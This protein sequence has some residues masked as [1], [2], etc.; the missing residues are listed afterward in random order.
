MCPVAGSSE[1]RTDTTSDFLALQ[2]AA[3]I[4]NLFHGVRRLLAAE[5][6]LSHDLGLAIP[7]F[8][9]SRD[10]PSEFFR[11]ST[12]PSTTQLLVLGERLSPL[13][14]R[15]SAR[16]EMLYRASDLLAAGSES[17]KAGL[18]SEAIASFSE[19]ARLVPNSTVIAAALARAEEALQTGFAFPAAP[20]PADSDDERDRRA[21]EGLAHARALAEAGSLETAIRLLRDLA[22]ELPAR[23]DLTDELG[24]LRASVHEVRGESSSG[25]GPTV[26]PAAPAMSRDVADG[27]LAD[28]PARTTPKWHPSMLVAAT[29]VLFLFGAFFWAWRSESPAM[30]EPVADVSNSTPGA[31]PLTGDL[32]LPPTPP[33]AAAPPQEQAH[34]VSVQ[35]AARVLRRDATAQAAVPIGTSSGRTSTSERPTSTLGDARLMA[36]K[37]PEE[38]LLGWRIRSKELERQ[39]GEGQNALNRS[40]FSRAIAVFSAIV[41]DD[42]GYADA[43]A[44]LDMA[45]RGRQASVSRLVDEAERLRQSADYEGAIVGYRQALELEPSL[46][47][48]AA[49]ISDTQRELR[50][51]GRQE[52]GRATVA[53]AYKLHA[54]AC[55]SYLAAARMLPPGDPD[56]AVAEARSTGDTTCGPGATWAPLQAS[57]LDLAPVAGNLQ[58]HRDK[59]G[60]FAFDYPGRPWKVIDGVGSTLVSLTNAN[61]SSIRIDALDLNESLSMLEQ[62]EPIA[63]VEMRLIEQRERGVS[64]VIARKPRPPVPLVIVDYKQLESS[65]LKQVRQYS[66][67]RGREL[68]RIVASAP[69]DVFPLVEGVF[70]QLARSFAPVPRH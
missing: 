68:F 42:P 52:F 37:R 39:Y 49:R 4:R 26:E 50:D 33:P 69:M 44:Q 65:G 14:D 67:I 19:A 51:L 16:V 7:A 48:I 22:T 66:C 5:A 55:A 10:V 47:N 3:R 38:S 70:D 63:I 41:A 9:A 32:P 27:A 18:P 46:P 29:V 31:V 21:S 13:Y 12:A 34:Q 54:E 60:R 6:G 11:D 61:G 64:Q 25:S 36:G 35:P 2:R 24:R 20:L 23:S 43:G 1:K 8:D 57:I 59:A 15:A 53:Y 40:D 28:H 45:K 56:R 17:L 62:G 58:T 30:P